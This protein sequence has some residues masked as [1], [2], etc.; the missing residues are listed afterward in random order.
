MVLFFVAD[1]DSNFYQSE[2]FSKVLQFVQARTRTA[3]M[4]EDKDRLSL[5]VENVENVDKAIGI[6]KEMGGVV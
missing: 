4:K 1:P 3:R 5:R 2:S 6:L